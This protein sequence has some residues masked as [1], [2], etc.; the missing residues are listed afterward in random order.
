M[1]KQSPGDFAINTSPFSLKLTK[2]WPKTM[3]FRSAILLAIRN[4]F[5]HPFLALYVLDKETLV[6]HQPA[7]HFYKVE[8][9]DLSV[10][11]QDLCL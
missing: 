7:K 11:T 10:K 8:I 1:I 9:Q 4:K 3:M 2:L 5:F 6:L